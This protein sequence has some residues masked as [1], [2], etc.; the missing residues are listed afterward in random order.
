LKAERCTAATTSAVIKLFLFK[1]KNK[2]GLIKVIRIQD[3]HHDHRE[4]E[5]HGG[6]RKLEVEEEE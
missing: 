6:G 5:A 2:I 4:T 1:Q 3:A